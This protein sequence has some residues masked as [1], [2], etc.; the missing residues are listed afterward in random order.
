MMIFDPTQRLTFEGAL[1]H[2]YLNSLHDISD[3]P[4]CLVP[5]SFDFEQHTLT[6]DQMR[7]LIYQEAF[8]FNPDYRRRRT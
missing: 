3:E 5:F 2:P 7:E 4:T 1:A 8:A 6:E